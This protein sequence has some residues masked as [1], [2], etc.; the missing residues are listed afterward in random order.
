MAKKK[1]RSRKKKKKNVL[2]SIVKYC[3]WY[4]IKYLGKGFM[5]VFYKIKDRK[6]NVVLDKKTKALI[7]KK[8]KTKILETIKGDYKVFWKNL[9]KSDSLI[10][11]V[12]GARG[13]G[14][15]A[16]ALKL[17]EELKGSKK[18]M[19]AMG[20]SSL[21]RW[22]KIVDDIHKIKNNSY[23]VIDEGG[24]LFSSRKSMTNAN[25]LLTDLLL[26]ARHKNL[27]I[28]FISQNSSNLDVNT[29]RQADFLILKKS[30]LLQKNF[31]R[32]VI[33]KT[34]DDYSSKFK[35]YKG[36]KGACLVYSDEFIGFI[37]NGLPSFWSA[38]VS[39]GFR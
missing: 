4:P 19:F 3:L 13:S 12:I 28:L 25:R 1:K 23:V 37:E 17:L 32:K 15:T 38:K 16:V 24:I 21:P 18:K 36:N 8:Y 10:G 39:K 30:S 31:E 20:F 34:Y 5:W 9:K 29:L 33:A 7:A 22:I 11:I 2:F 6:E 35:L 27:T 14:K 26:I